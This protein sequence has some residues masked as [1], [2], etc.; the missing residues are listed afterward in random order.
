MKIENNARDMNTVFLPNA[1]YSTTRM[2]LMTSKEKIES[3]INVVKNPKDSFETVLFLNGNKEGRKEGGLR[4]KGLFKQ[5]KKEAPLV[6]IITTVFNGEQFLEE[7]ILSVINQD[8][9]NVEYIIIDGGSNDG[10]LDIIKKYESMIDYWAS[11][12]D[13]SMYE[14]INKGII[15]SL[16]D[17]VHCLNS[18]DFYCDNFVITKLIGNACNADCV[19]GNIVKL[20]QLSKKTTERK[21]FPVSFFQ[22]LAS[23]HSTFLPQPTLFIKKNV[24]KKIGLYDLKYLYAADYHLNLRLLSTESIL[25]HMPIPVVYFR[26]HESSIT[27]SYVEL[28]KERLKVL[29][30]FQLYEKKYTY[31]VLVYVY[32]WLKYKVIN[33][34]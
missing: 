16:G 7:A 27:S 30:E 26:N 21:I 10:T 2:L 28:N 29:K 1:Q 34:L 18:D 12:K 25:K 23:K 19:Y 20:D 33:A 4:T 22:L 3:R 13:R 32:L 14:G 11:E 9:D 5:S 8:Y 15:L 31:R 6:T 17:Y 24:Y